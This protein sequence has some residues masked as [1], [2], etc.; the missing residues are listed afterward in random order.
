MPGG[1]TLHIRDKHETVA[2]RHNLWDIRRQ[3]I[4]DSIGIIVSWVH[5]RV[6]SGP[7]YY[8]H[9]HHTNVERT[10]SLQERMARHQVT[11]NYTRAT[12]M[13]AFTKCS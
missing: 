7:R 3:A 1:I 10:I 12:T 8:I 9:H 5:Y 6:P 13:D 2:L 4:K 11:I